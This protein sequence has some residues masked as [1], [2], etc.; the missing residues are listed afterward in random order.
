MKKQILLV[1]IVAAFQLTQLQAQSTLNYPGRYM[2][3]EDVKTITAPNGAVAD[4]GFAQ[5]LQLIY[6]QP[7]VEKTADGIWVI[8]GYSITNVVVIESDEGLIVIDTGDS[9]EEGIK[10]REVIRENISKKPI[11]AAIYTHSHYCMGTGVMVDDPKTAII[12]G[13]KRLNET[14]QNNFMSG[15]AIAQIPELGP[16]L[17]ARQLIQ[18]SN[19]LPDTG[20]DGLLG[21]RYRIKENAYLPANKIVDD[22]EIVDIG[23]IAFQFFTEYRSD[24][25]NLTVWLPEQK[26]VMNNFYWPGTPNLYSIRGA[27][28]RD[29]REW[30]NG[31]QVIR[32]LKPEVMMNTH[33]KTVQGSKEV[34]DAISNYMDMVTLVYDQSL[35][36]IL[37]GLGPDEL[38]YFVYQPK[39]LAAFPNNAQAYG[40]VPW[41][42]PAAF[43]HQMGW[44]DRNLSTLHKLPPVEEAQRTVALMGGRKKVLQAAKASFA[45]REFAW[46]AQLGNYLFTIDAKDTEA[47]KLLADVYR[48]MGQT[49]LSVIGRSF[50]LSEARALEGE[51]QIPRVVPP[52]PDI[53]A[54]KPTFFVDMFRVRIDPKKSEN[55][56]KMLVFNFSNGTTAGL[57]VRRGIAEFVPNPA[58]HYR[59]ADISCIVDTKTWADLYLNATT[60]DEAAKSG[61]VKMTKGSMEDLKF[62]MDLFDKFDPAKNY[63]IPL[64]NAEDQF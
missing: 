11:I 7:T 15:G 40:E 61:G 20:A 22:G 58:N 57:H 45:K 39:H 23:G 8:G 27:S 31:L 34:F 52:K 9:K 64:T 44:F 47:R 2:G 17:T 29:P 60:L 51:V 42:T 1:L 12:V 56:E 36:G 43:Y 63:T 19:F 18:F 32:D 6:P 54:A 50:F 55:T 3:R 33:A 59:P 4:A 41:F 13:H 28:Y 21:Q 48:A 30:R 49:S 24:D 14:V 46:A 26:V 38:R 53:I 35:R 5:T 16:V 37:H 25:F 10:L 62:V